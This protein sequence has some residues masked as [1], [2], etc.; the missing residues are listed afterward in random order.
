VDK[1][2]PW[3]TQSKQSIYDNPWIKVDEAKVL[4]PAGKSGIYG[5]VHFKA[6][7][8]GVVPL[9]SKMETYLVGQ[10]RYPVDEYSWEIPEGGCPLGT[11]PLDSAKREL[12]EETGLLA[13]RWTRGLD[14][15]WLSNSVC[16]ESAV[17]F[18][19]QDL[20]MG[21]AEPEDTEDITLWKL[22]LQEAYEMACQGKIRDI[23]SVLSL[24]QTKAMLDRGELT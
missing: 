20:E 7:A 16:D 5:T 23:L 9:T 8:V 22:P 21:E 15:L 11:D 18:V 6:L 13:K 10:Y 1:N 17:F 3:V 2:N 14:R 19:A 4:N 12:K 24:I